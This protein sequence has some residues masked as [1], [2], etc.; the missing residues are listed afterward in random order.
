MFSLNFNYNESES[1][2]EDI[3][4]DDPE[5]VP[6]SVTDLEDEVPPSTLTKS[7]VLEDKKSPMMDT[8]HIS[9]ITANKTS[10][11]RT[12][13]TTIVQKGNFF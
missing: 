5:Y 12:D 4:D 13:P 10:T 11:N 8:S 7:T 1:S 6:A 9:G 3:S 2:E